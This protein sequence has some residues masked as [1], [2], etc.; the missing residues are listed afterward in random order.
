MAKSKVRSLRKASGARYGKMYRKK[1]LIDLMGIPT[2]AHVAETVRTKIKRV[3]GGNKVHALVNASHANVT[4]GKKTFKV[5]IKS[6]LENP[7][8]RHFVRQNV[9]T[10]GAIIDTEK[11]KARVTS[12]PSKQNI[13][14][15]VLV[16]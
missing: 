10:K 15:A 6:V 14:N 12:R 16:K 13:V 7:A 2:L 1:K 11:G 3:R 4:D 8:S 9:V 5:K